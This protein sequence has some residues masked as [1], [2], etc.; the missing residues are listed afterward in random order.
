[1]AL[2]DIK[3]LFGQKMNRNGITAECVQ[4]EHIKLLRRIALHRKPSIT[5]RNLDFALTTRRILE[6]RC[7]EALHLRID[8]VDVDVISR[9][10]VCC[11]RRCSQPDKSNATASRVECV[12]RQT[13]AA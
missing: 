9:A 11:Q 8:F 1:M 2:I 13:D 4:G 5:E 3:R 6:S 10:A 7:R 12:Y